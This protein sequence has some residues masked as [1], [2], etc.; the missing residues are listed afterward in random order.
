MNG[1]VFT[2]HSCGVTQ[3][4]D[5]MNVDAQSGDTGY[6]PGPLD[7]LDN[8]SGNTGFLPGYYKRK[9]VGEVTEGLSFDKFMD[10]TLIAEAKTQG[11]PARQ[12]HPQRQLARSYQEH[13]LGKTRIGRG[14][15]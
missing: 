5:A 6:K 12:I 2:C 9:P 10:A 8:P 11:E 7:N 3:K 4:R 15:R 13:P 14:G 1:D